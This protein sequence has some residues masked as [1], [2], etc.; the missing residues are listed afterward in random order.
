MQIGLAILGYPVGALDGMLGTRTQTAWS[1]F[2]TDVHQGDPDMLGPDSVRVLETMARV[3][4]R[5]ISLPKPQ[6]SKRF[7]RNASNRESD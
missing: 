1:E 3:L 6:R 2:K 4:E 7:E 5:T